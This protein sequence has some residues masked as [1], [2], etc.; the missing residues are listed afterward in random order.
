MA[1]QQ[2]VTIPIPGDLRPDEREEFA[3]GVIDYIRER[4]QTGTGV[5]KRGRGFQVYQFPEYS[6]EYLKNLA[7]VGRSKSTVDLTLSESMLESI[8]LLRHK[9]GEITIGFQRGSKENDKAEGNQLGTYG[10]S[11][12]IPGKARRFLGLTRDEIDTLL[13]FY[14]GG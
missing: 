14:E 2:K 13:E 6:E 12:P 8:E 5:R 4:T 1:E 11:R 9:K 7:R 3:Q 10:Q